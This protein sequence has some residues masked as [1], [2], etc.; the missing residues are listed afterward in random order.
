MRYGI[1]KKIRTVCVCL[2]KKNRGPNTHIY[3]NP[4]TPHPQ[5]SST[6]VPVLRGGQR[7]TNRQEV[8]P[9]KRPP[10]HP[11]PNPECERSEIWLQI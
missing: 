6:P 10:S 8:A 5:Y 3:K 2:S 9:S 11:Q 4:A 1:Q 7:E